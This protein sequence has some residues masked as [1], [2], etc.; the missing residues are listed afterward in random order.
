MLLLMKKLSW[1]LIQSLKTKA[2]TPAVNSRKKMIPRN[3]ENWKIQT[4]TAAWN[5]KA[6]QREASLKFR[7]YQVT[8]KFQ[9]ERVFSQCAN[10][11]GKS[12]D[13]HHSAHHQEEPDWVKTPKV[14]DGWDVGED[15]LVKNKEKQNRTTEFYLKCSS[16]TWAD[17]TIVPL[18]WIQFDHYQSLIG[19]MSRMI[20][21]KEHQNRWT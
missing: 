17:L 1:S 12:K 4:F 13:E 3:T 11:T 8:Y 19:V 21:W 6:A 16:K 14:R 20:W 9:Q 7:D 15:A 18:M 2:R 10:A 5:S